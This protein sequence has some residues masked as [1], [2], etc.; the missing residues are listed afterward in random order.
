M[1]IKQMF[2]NIQ[3]GKKAKKEVVKKEIKVPKPL[4]EAKEIGVPKP[5]KEAKE[6]EVP[7][8]LEESVEEEN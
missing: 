8:P 4:E 3:E 5:L 2:Q 1:D 6:I 7:K